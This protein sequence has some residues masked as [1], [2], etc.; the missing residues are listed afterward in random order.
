MEEMQAAEESGEFVYVEGSEGA[1]GTQGTATPHS[2]PTEAV[3]I[4]W[5][6]LV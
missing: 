1:E 3:S 2:T 4:S 5:L 6:D